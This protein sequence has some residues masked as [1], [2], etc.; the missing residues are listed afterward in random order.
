MAESPPARGSGPNRQKGDSPLALALLER[1][2]AG[3]LEPPSPGSLAADLGTKRQILEGVQGHL[4]TQG[5]LVRL[6]SGLILSAAAV[7]DLRRRLEET[8]WREF[9][10][11]EFKARFDLS[12]KW[13]IPLLEHLDEVGATRRVG[14]R[15]AL[16]RPAAPDDGEGGR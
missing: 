14:D 5:R 16:L 6:G 1:M 13:A 4:V 7:D 8:G 12:R 15:R 10:I 2:E 9:T 3:G 11:A